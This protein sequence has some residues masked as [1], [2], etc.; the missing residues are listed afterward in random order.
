MLG[1]QEILP[2]PGVTQSRSKEQNTA[3]SVSIREFQSMLNPNPVTKKRKIYE[4]L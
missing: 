4:N 1:I 3:G 2:S